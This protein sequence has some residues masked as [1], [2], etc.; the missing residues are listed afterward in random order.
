CHHNVGA[1]LPCH[2]GDAVAVR[3]YGSRAACGFPSPADDY[4][5]S[6]LDLNELCISNTVSTFFVRAEGDSMQGV[7]IEDG[8]LL[9][10]DRSLDAVSGDVVVACVDGDL[11]VKRYVVSRGQA[12]LSPASDAYPVIALHEGREWS[13]WGV[14]TF[15]I[16]RHRGR[17]VR[18]ER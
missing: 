11:T 12:F 17:H 13:I 14:V 7:G 9:V 3:L 10:V 16:K 8:D 18:A 6:A 15:T 1:I 4:V 5:E 2:V